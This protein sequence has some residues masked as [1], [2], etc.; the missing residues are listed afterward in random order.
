M[1]HDLAAGIELMHALG[2]IAK[3][4]QVSADVANLVFMRF[5]HVE[6]KDVFARV[7]AAL[8]FFYLNFGD[9]SPR[10]PQNS[11]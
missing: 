11:S 1:G 7:Q 2:Q 5:A 8:E 10:I 6:H 4:N 9:S 3:R